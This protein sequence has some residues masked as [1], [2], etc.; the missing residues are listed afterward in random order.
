M[1]VSDLLQSL[2]D[3][4]KYSE[5]EFEPLDNHLKKMGKNKLTL[6]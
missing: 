5:K 3:F 6:S 4:K 1:K 2:N